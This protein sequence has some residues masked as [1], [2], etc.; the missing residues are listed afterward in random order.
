MEK[1]VGRWK[2]TT[3]LHANEIIEELGLPGLS[4]K[5]ARILH[6]ATA[7]LGDL[8]RLSNIQGTCYISDGAVVRGK[9]KHLMLIDALARTLVRQDEIVALVPLKAKVDKVELV[10][11]YSDPSNEIS[12]TRNPRQADAFPGSEL[13]MTIWVTLDRGLD[14]NVNIDGD[15]FNA[16][17]FFLR[18][19]KDLRFDEHVEIVT[20][21]LKLFY[22]EKVKLD[23]THES[24]GNIDQSERK[25]DKI[26]N[27]FIQYIVAST[28]NKIVN[29]FL[30]GIKKR[31]FWFYLG[32]PPTTDEVPKK[33]KEMS[34]VFKP[35]SDQDNIHS[36]PLL[37]GD[38]AFSEEVRVLFEKTRGKIAAP[39]KEYD[40]QGRHQFDDLFRHWLSKAF[41]ESAM[42]EQVLTGL[43]K[44]PEKFDITPDLEKDVARQVDTVFNALK[45]LHT[46]ISEDIFPEHL[47]WIQKAH[48]LTSTTSSIS[49]LGKRDITKSLDSGEFDLDRESWEA[50]MDV[51]MKA[52]TIFNRQEIF[53]TKGTGRKMKRGSKSSKETETG[54]E[55]KQGWA[56]ACERWLK[57]V[58]ATAECTTRLLECKDHKIKVGLSNLEVIIIQGTATGYPRETAS[59][60]DV[61]LRNGEQRA[62]KFLQRKASENKTIK[63]PGSPVKMSGTIHC[64]AILVSLY[65]LVYETEKVSNRIP[66]DP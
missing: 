26:K 20:K 37:E 45:A 24:G 13:D 66:C 5:E 11:S 42:L 57:L 25:C 4:K 8:D 39:P 55:E 65:L 56:V 22:Q 19:I 6:G 23:T 54:P 18:S 15:S 43:L 34:I 16:I 38:P 63:P 30:L 3:Q 58:C 48:G 2:D 51:S 50:A 41:E 35:S 29:S 52:D 14:R 62:V 60:S 21:H 9:K 33:C 31:N 36:L 64:E 59:A 7:L 1:E 17:R 47:Q 44:S 61:L 10:A 27:N 49:A 28:V 12:V 40:R 46:I 32:T 53:E